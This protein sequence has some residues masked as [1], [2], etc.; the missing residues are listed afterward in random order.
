MAFDLRP[1][2]AAA[3]ARAERIVAA[4]RLLIGLSLFGVLLVTLPG[5]ADAANWIPGKLI[6]Q[7]TL[8]VITITTY[9]MMGVVTLTICL[10]GFYRGWMVWPFATADALVALA[11]LWMGL[12]NMGLIGAYAPLIPASW[13]MVIVL[14]FGTLRY[15]PWLQVWLTALIGTGLII[16][17]G[18]TGGLGADPVPGGG[19]IFTTAPPTVMRIVMLSAAGLIIALAVWRSRR[20]LYEAIEASQ[21]RANLGRYL[22][23]QISE[24]LETGDIADLRRGRRGRL[25][26][27]FVDLRQF[28]ARAEQM[29]PDDLS[30]FMTRFRQ[31]ITRIA[32][33]TG[34]AV[35]K[36]V[37]DG[38]MLIFGLEAERED[39][40][41]S[42]LAAARRLTDGIA[43]FEDGDL[44]LAM[45]AH[46]GEAFCGVVGDESRLE[47]TVLGDVVN[48]A[49]RLEGRAKTENASLVVSAALLQRAHEDSANWH[50]LGL[51]EIR[52]RQEPV[53]LFAR[54]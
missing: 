49:A 12:A 25:A 22:P 8:A 27:L 42:A 20:N 16:V 48:V 17:I 4:I 14:A 52:G 35:D 50:A 23:R 39:D 31:L 33:Q 11:S 21:R 54:P 7:R 34:G 30:A 28:T 3:D 53:Q 26:V 36:F 24:L 45:G 41:A 44:R 10:T 46:W 32:D 13:L 6:D 18:M 19:G 51:S 2:L 38:A 47:F 15:N 5:A 9:L 40:A 1:F 43:T 37:G 29:T